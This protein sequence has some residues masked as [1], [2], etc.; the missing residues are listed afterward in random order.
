M[1]VVSSLA[2]F[3]M[4]TITAVKKH[5]PKHIVTNIFVRNLHPYVFSNYARAFTNKWLTRFL[6][7]K[8]HNSFKKCKSQEKSFIALGRE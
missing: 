5:S 2:H 8:R 3:E 4:A 1:A 7:C 6:I